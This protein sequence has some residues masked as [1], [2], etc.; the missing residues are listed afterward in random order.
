MA[1]RSK[2]SIWSFVQNT[3]PT[4]SFDGC[5]WFNPDTGESWVWS[6]LFSV[7]NPFRLSVTAGAGS[8]AYPCGGDASGSPQNRIDKML[9]STES[10]S[11]LAS[12]LSVARHGGASMH[13]LPAGF[14]AGGHG[15]SFTSVIDRLQFSDDTVAAIGATVSSSRSRMSGVSSFVK[16]YMVGGD[17]SDSY[18]SAVT[19]IDTLLFNGLTRTT[20][21]VGLNSAKTFFSDN[22]VESSLAGYTSGGTNT[23]NTKQT[24]IDKILFTTDAIS[25]LATTLA[26]AKQDTAGVQSVV[27]GYIAGGDTGSYVN[28]IEKLTFSGTEARSAVTS[29][30]S[31]SRAQFSGSS[32]Y[33]AGFFHAGYNGSYLN[34]TDKLTFSSEARTSVTSTLSV[35]AAFRGCVSNAN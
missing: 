10:V 24:S 17:P 16:G 14:Y 35:S 5:T 15:A 25:T 19:T 13:S 29:T 30:L 1:K 21:A 7:W 9:F 33:L 4:P 32:S 23:G 27:A 3:T 22:G 2:R 28:T 18:G 6:A 11:S 20:L 12:G 26:T 31:V 34:S 8:A